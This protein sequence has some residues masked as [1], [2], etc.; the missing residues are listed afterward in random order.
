MDRQAMT[1]EETM[2]HA[3]D[4]LRAGRLAEAEALF[5]GLLAEVPS[6]PDALHL[7][8]CTMS[9]LGRTDEAVELIQ[10]AINLNPR[11]AA[12]H[13]NLGLTLLGIG[14]KREAIAALEQSLAIQPNQPDAL[15][16]LAKILYSVGELDRAII[17][18]HRAI[19]AQPSDPTLLFNLGNCWLRKA[20]RIPLG[21]DKAAQKT[22][23]LNN[24]VAC[25]EKALTLS[26]GYGNAG[27][28]LGNT[29]RV[30]GRTDEAI[31][32]WRR[33]VSAGPHSLAYFNLGRALYEKD[34][35]DEALD[36]TRNSIRID[37]NNSDAYNNLG[38]LL[39]QNGAVEEGIRQF[40]RALQINPKSPVVNSNRLYTLYYDPQFSAKAILLEH[41]QWNDRIARP[42]AQTPGPHGNDLSPDR[43]LKIGYVSPN[44][45][46]HCQSFFTVP[47]LSNHD[48]RN[49]E[50]HCY[51]DVKGPDAMTGRL[52]GWADSW[53]NIVG[54][55]HDQA[56]EMIRNDRIDILVDLTLHMA[57]NRILLFA[58]KPAPLQITWL[59]YPGTTGLETMDYRFTDPYLDPPG[60]FDECYSEKSVRLPHTFWC[61]D[62]DAM[63]AP[64]VPEVNALP[65]I[66]AGHITFGCLNN[67]CKVNQPL[68]ELWKR[69]LDMVGNS[70][71]V[72]LAPSGSCRNW[73][74]QTLGER[75]DFVERADRLEYLKYYHRLD[76]GLDTLPYNGHT[77][78][79]D[80]LWMGVPVVTLA[81]QTVVG[82]AG[83]SQLSN[84]GLTDLVTRTPDQFVKCASDLAADLTRLTE[85]RRTLRDRM[86]ASPLL[87][88][89][90][91]SKDVESAY[92]S[93]WK[94]HCGA[95]K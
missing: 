32:A 53:R 72:L 66:E 80:S 55:S 17:C 13:G 36:A 24:A 73:V 29:L 51:S 33:T 67:F 48:H 46:G 30:L 31:A 54:V 38:N 15:V 75:V 47:L 78:T 21:T 4:E 14:R 35:V 84:L 43:R 7:L 62:R 10:R 3:C 1:R 23:N 49:F 65:A 69:V 39:R 81:G 85:L 90:K 71:M 19:K 34:L 37:P 87:D 22:E 88:G 82:R 68:L 57:E 83:F 11:Q 25:F 52:R 27:N 77:T 50:I 12:Y 56:A 89:P 41:R 61:L 6:W 70:R 42:L 8:G 91:F 93:I 16:L 44:F 74:R 18:F 63:E 20:S 58:R 86:R 9:K 79:L 5:R 45:W 95:A 59:G 60:E 26:P 2:K 64:D 76:I 94:L 92:R 40:D 28:N